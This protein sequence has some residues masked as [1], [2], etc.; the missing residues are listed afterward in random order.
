MCSCC[1]CTD[2]TNSS[3]RTSTSAASASAGRRV[4]TTSASGRRV[5]SNN[6]TAHVTQA[7]LQELL[8]RPLPSV[9]VVC[10]YAS[11]LPLLQKSRRVHWRGA[12][13]LYFCQPRARKGQGLTFHPSKRATVHRLL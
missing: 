11:T 6:S 7:A 5:G 1:L 13:L 9:R 12:F 2:C 8:L 4:D 10:S 3:F